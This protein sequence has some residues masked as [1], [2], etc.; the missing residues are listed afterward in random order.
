[1]NKILQFFLFSLVLVALTGC[2]SRIAVKK[3][4][5]L[6]KES[7]KGVVILSTTES[8]KHSIIKPFLSLRTVGKKNEY[9]LKMWNRKYLDSEGEVALLGL[10]WAT[11]E[12]PEGK[13]IGNLHVIELNKGVYEFY[14]YSATFNGPFVTA[15]FSTKE[16]F[17]W[18]FEVEPG[19]A[20]YLG[21]IDLHNLNSDDFSL[22]V[23]IDDENIRDLKLIKDNYPN[24][25]VHDIKVEIVQKSPGDVLPK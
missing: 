13:T 2:N 25:P 19:V 17:S 5:C 1:M 8:G 23:R 20:K 3:D 12:I 11:P 14:S 10:D 9:D 7:G 22:S 18:K 24:I 15:F 4:Y 16:E 6:S 21:N